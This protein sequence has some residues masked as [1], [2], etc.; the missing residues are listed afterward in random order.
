MLD[1]SECLSLCLSCR[2]SPRLLA[3]R[4]IEEA[5][6]ARDHL[7]S[8]YRSLESENSKLQE[9]INQSQSCLPTDGIPPVPSARRSRDV[10]NARF[11]RHVA[12]RTRKNWRFYPYSLMLKD[13]FEQYQSLVTCDTREDFFRSLHDWKNKSLQLTQLRPL[14][15]QTVMT[16]GQTTS[17]TSAP[18]R[19]AEEFSRLANSDASCK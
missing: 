3:A 9:K 13:A 5:V 12:E 1:S 17:F 16:I 7:L 8:E 6:Q 19:V 4:C 2:S 11:R 14:A 18:E 15:M 10:L